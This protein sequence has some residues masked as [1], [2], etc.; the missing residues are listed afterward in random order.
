MSIFSGGFLNEEV[1]WCTCFNDVIVSDGLH[2]VVASGVRSGEYL[3]VTS[4]GW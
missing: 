2:M 4:Y 3:N 1:L